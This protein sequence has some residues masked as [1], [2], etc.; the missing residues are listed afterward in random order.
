MKH[1]TKKVNILIFFVGGGLI[2]KK[3]KLGQFW[4]GI[5]GFYGRSSVIFCPEPRW[6]WK[7]LGSALPL[8]T[9]WSLMPGKYNIIMGI[10]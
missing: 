2:N 6:D 3:E 5:I 7:F 1:E 4:K 9:V 10:T 8:N